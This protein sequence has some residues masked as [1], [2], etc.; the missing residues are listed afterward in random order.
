MVTPTHMYVDNKVWMTDT[1]TRNLYRLDI[2]TGKWE[3]LGIS[4]VADRQISGYGLPSDAQNNVYMMEFGNANI[5]RR[6]AKTLETKIWQTP[7]QRSRPRRGR[8]LGS[9]TT[10]APRSSASRRWSERTHRAD[11]ARL[12]ARWSEQGDGRGKSP[13]IGVT[14]FVYLA[15]PARSVSGC[16]ATEHLRSLPNAACF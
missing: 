7:I 10:T 16:A 15:T 5:G 12:I 2:K 11:G 4:K 14:G 3:N 6:D 9:A 1:A 8:F 13:A